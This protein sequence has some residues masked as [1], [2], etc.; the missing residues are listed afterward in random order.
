MKKLI[1]TLGIAGALALGVAGCNSKPEI[2]RTVKSGV[3][4]SGMRYFTYQIEVQSWDYNDRIISF[5]DGTNVRT[6]EY[7]GDKDIAGNYLQTF[8]ITQDG[9]YVLEDGEFRSYT[10]SPQSN[11][12]HWKTIAIGSSQIR[13]ETIKNSNEVFKQLGINRVL[14]EGSPSIEEAREREA[15]SK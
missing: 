4:N 3:L 5:C 6:L 15:R 11:T 10:T 9:K 13:N 1:S 7:L 8:D 12:E 2:D 14:H